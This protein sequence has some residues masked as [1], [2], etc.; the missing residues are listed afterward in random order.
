M[1][2]SLFICQ[3]F[4]HNKIIVMMIGTCPLWYTS[5]TEILFQVMYSLVLNYDSSGNFSL[6]KRVWRLAQ[7]SWWA[8]FLWPKTSKFFGFYFE[9]CWCFRQLSWLLLKTKKNMCVSGRPTDPIILPPTLTFCMPKKIIDRQ[10]LEIRLHFRVC[11]RL[12][13]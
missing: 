6:V 4:V 7:F 3:N 5:V 8:P 13:Q 10:N 11:F 9:D 2:N 12:Q 1:R